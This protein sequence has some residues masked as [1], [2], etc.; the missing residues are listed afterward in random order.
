MPVVEL[1]SALRMG[2]VTNVLLN[3][4]DGSVESFDVARVGETPAR[5]VSAEDI[6]RI[7]K[8]ALVMLPAA[9]WP[10]PAQDE[11]PAAS[12]DVSTITGLEV[13]ADTGDRVGFI[14]DVLVNPE[15][16]AIELYELESPYWERRF[17]GQR[18][19]RS[20]SVLICSHEIMLIRTGD[21]GGKL[22]VDPDFRQARTD[23][24]WY[25]RTARV[26]MSPAPEDPDLDQPAARSA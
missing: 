12:L 3:P 14:A 8:D 7:G 24:E 1:S 19:I 4:N 21:A 9:R 13:L 6:R 23:D 16:L 15:T 18:R 25:G 5:N 20:A 11:A 26:P 22:A 2:N 10:R 17:R